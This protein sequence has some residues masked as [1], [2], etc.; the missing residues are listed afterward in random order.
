MMYKKYNLWIGFLILFFISTGYATAQEKTTLKIMCYNLRFGE[1]ASLEELAE[2]IKKENPDIVALQEVDVNTMRTRA[3]HQNGKNFISEL[4]FRTGMLSLY[5]KTIPYAGGY[6]GIGI[7]SKYPFAS[8][9]RILLPMPEGA[10]EQRA[11]LISEVELPEKQTITFACTHLDY[12]TSEV[13][14][15][16]VKFINNIL[17]QSESPAILC[18][19]FNAKPDSKEINIDMNDWLQAA[20]S[21]YTIPAKAPKSKIDYIFCYPKN[22]WTIEDAYTP[23]VQLSDHLPVISILTLN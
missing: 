21:D 13:R 12:T 9:K 11:V 22:I 3:P 7:L 5:G 15:A 4:A 16:Q 18:G 6:Y 17:L 14:Q 20:S 19:D 2:F 23:K 10:K 8:S 1:L